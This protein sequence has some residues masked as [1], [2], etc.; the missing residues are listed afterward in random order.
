[1]PDQKRLLW[2]YGRTAAIAFIPL[3][4][5]LAAILFAVLYRLIGWP[6]AAARDRIIIAVL[7]LSV[8]PLLLLLLDF[9][10]SSRARVDTPWVKLD[11]TQIIN[12]PNIRVDSFE[13][14]RNIETPGTRLADSAA[15]QIQAALQ[16]ATDSPVVMLDIKGGEA[17][18]VTR[19]LALSAGAARAGAPRAL[20]FVGKEEN[21]DGLF[22][23]WV[24]PEDALQAIL[25]SR[26]EYQKRYQLARQVAQQLAMYGG[27]F[28]LLPQLPSPPISNPQPVRVQMPPIVSRYMLPDYAKLG[29]AAFEQILMDMLTASFS[30]TGDPDFVALE[31]PPDHLTL[32]R[33]RDLF[34]HCLYRTYID[35]NWDNERKIQVFL[36]STAPFVA[37]VNDGKFESMIER[38]AGNG[39]IL[40]QLYRAGLKSAEGDGRRESR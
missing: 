16:D 19:L 28:D 1:M 5:I 23:G 4:W 8:V 24:R 38:A 25:R 35:R 26:G 36:E 29:D 22:L 15:M 21:R 3:A 33:L 27:T 11:F 6:D 7:I 34:G 31:N 30:P 12:E 14:P 40:L 39:S 37:L 10:S 32:A 18:W 2:P 9:A 20:V 17:W 13:L